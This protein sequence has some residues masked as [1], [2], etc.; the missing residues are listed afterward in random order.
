MYA[1]TLMEDMSA[2]ESHVPYSDQGQDVALPVL[3]NIAKLHAL[4]F[5]DVARY[6]VK[7][8]PW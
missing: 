7:K 6:G 2:Y 5:N 4:T 3:A 1:V 8:T